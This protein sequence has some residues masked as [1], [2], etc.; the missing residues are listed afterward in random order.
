MAWE[1]ETVVFAVKAVFAPPK[2]AVM[3][4]FKFGF[5]HFAFRLFPFFAHPGIQKMF[6]LV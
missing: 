1:N 6:L 5:G 2:A 4:F 3:F